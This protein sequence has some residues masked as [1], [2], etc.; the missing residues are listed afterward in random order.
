M[1]RRKSVY[2]EAGGTIVGTRKDLHMLATVKNKRIPAVDINASFSV[3]LLYQ[4]LR[5][6]FQ[7]GLIP[8]PCR[9]YNGNHLLVAVTATDFTRSMFSN[10]PVFSWKHIPFDYA[11]QFG[12]EVRSETTGFNAPKRGIGLLCST[13]SK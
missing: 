7:S 4:R 11:F 3:F 10:K 8:I 6:V 5:F 9:W 1:L 13:F 2:D 12:Q